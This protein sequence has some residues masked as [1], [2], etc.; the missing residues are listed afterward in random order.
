ML[1]AKQD[2]EEEQIVA[3]AGE[4][5]RVLIATNMAGRGTHIGLSEEAEKS[6]GL[7]VIQVE[8]NESSRIDRQLIGRGARQ[9]QPG[10]SQGFISGE[11]YLVT[12]HDPALAQ[13]MQS[14]RADQYGEL[15]G[16]WTQTFDR[17]QSEVERKRYSRESS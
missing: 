15:T 16:N 5:G 7:H 17:L 8:R 10:S 4:A 9:G 3:Q 14:A 13:K 2:K 11:D 1:T 12:S 6:G